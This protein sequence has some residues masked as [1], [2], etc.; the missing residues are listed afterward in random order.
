[1]PDYMDPV[2]D[3]VASRTAKALEAHA[4]RDESGPQ[5]VGY[6]LECGADLEAPRR[7]CDAECRDSWERMEARRQQCRS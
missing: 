3:L 4:N 6:C 2:Q 7:W 1:M 5:Y